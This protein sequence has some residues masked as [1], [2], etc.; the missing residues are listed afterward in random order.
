MSVEI[1]VRRYYLERYSRNRVESIKKNFRKTGR[2]VG[3]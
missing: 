3:R 2:E 1:P